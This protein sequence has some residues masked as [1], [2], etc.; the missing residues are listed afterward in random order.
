M[1]PNET[2]SFL[3]TK[4]NWSCWQNDTLYKVLNGILITAIAVFF[5][6]TLRDGHNWDGDY[7]LYIMH[8]RNI[9]EGLPYADTGYIYN[10]K[11]PMNPAS[12]PPGL[13]LLL[14][15]I[16]QFYGID[17]EKMKMVV[18]ISFIL[19]LLIFSCIMRQSLPWAMALA[20][21]ATVGLHFQYWR[22]KDT[23][24]SEFPFMLF[25]YAALYGIDSLTQI[26]ATPKLWSILVIAIMLALAC[27]TRGIGL[28]LFPIIFLIGVYQWR[29]LVNPCLPIL[30]I[31]AAII[32]LV[33]FL[34]PQDL[35][36]H[37]GPYENYLND[38]I[39]ATLKPNIIVQRSAVRELVVHYAFGENWLIDRLPL[40]FFLLVLVGLITRVRIHLSIY[41]AF[42]SA[43]TL[44]LVTYPGPGATNEAVRYLLP[45]WPLFLFYVV[46]GTYAIGSRLGG[47]WQSVL[48]AML[49]GALLSLHVA[50]YT[51][52]DFGS[53]RYSVTDPISREL[54][55]NIKT[56]LPADAVVL[57]GKPTIMALFSDRRAAIWPANF[58]D[59]EVWRYI[60]EVGAGYIVALT[61][62][63]GKNRYW[64]DP[65]IQAFIEQNQSALRLLFSNK[66]FNLY[67]VSDN[68][69]SWHKETSYT[70]GRRPHPA[71]ASN[72]GSSDP[73]SSSLK[74]NFTGIA[75]Q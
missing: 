24:F 21:T 4:I 2:T 7:A 48:P 40:V 22:F 19:F 67:Q 41:E 34:F 35:T 53:I 60:N 58:N 62:D 16:Y 36:Y 3:K 73:A 49:C 17:L 65:K 5:F 57:F 15:P 18:V 23:I 47:I 64:W 31:A 50:Q 11:N 1:K 9:V 52:T 27:L 70:L 38:G 63:F 69:A 68:H 14:A 33:N 66:W 51:R 20:V 12:Y 59:D 43:Y 37:L 45:I 8:A 26:K 39:F 29:R 46:Y 55:N 25:C 72:R 75:S 13:P 32:I 44:F 56:N 30:A 74:L 71:L 61:G 42:L 54:F 10:P 28:M 6:S